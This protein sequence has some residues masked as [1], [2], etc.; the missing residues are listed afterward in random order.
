MSRRGSVN[1]LLMLAVSKPVTN[2]MIWE[3][4]GVI[5]LLWRN[6]RFIYALIHLL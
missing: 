3:Y 4:R 2:N 6:T 1:V 5:H